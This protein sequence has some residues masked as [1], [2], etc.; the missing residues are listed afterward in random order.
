MRETK[1]I[2]E[3][4]TKTETSVVVCN[5]CGKK[6]EGEDAQY[7][8][9]ITDVRVEFGYGSKFDTD[10]WEFDICDDCIEEIT[11]SFVVPVT[12]REMY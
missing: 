4:V 9:D 2:T 8:S 10:V 7:S 6:V 3:T 11:K 5:R 1:E 12:K